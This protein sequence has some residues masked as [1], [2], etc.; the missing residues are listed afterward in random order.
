MTLSAEATAGCRRYRGCDSTRRW[1]GCEQLQS[2]CVEPGKKAEPVTFPLGDDAGDTPVATASPLIAITM[3]IAE[4]A[5]Q[6]Q[7]PG[8]SV[9]DEFDFQADQLRS[10][11]RKAVV[12]SVGPAVLR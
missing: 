11:V 1:Q 10:R 8:R 2:L 5:S 3:G 7:A 9:G 4:V 12:L 6:P